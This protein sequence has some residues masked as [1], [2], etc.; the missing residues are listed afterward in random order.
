MSTNLTKCFSLYHVCSAYKEAIKAPIYPRKA[1]VSM[2][3]QLLLFPF[4]CF[5]ICQA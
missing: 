4:N 1:V 5:G 2:L 3:I